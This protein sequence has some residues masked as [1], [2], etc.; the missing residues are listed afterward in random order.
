[1][2]Q[3]R[4]H[5]AILDLLGVEQA[6]VAL[7]KSDLVENDWLD[8]VGAE[9]EDLLKG[10]S[11]E[12]SQIISC[13]ATSREGLPD[14]LSALQEALAQTPPKRDMGRPRLPIDRAFTVSGFGTVVTAR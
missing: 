12:G 2:P 11:L 3:T 1:M 7:T 8:L 4:E 14:L 10:T 5:L 13:S 6:V 9:V